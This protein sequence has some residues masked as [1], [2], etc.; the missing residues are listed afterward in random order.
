VVGRRELAAGATVA[1]AA[2]QSIAHRRIVAV[3]H[4]APSLAEAT[5]MARHAIV[6]PETSEIM[7]D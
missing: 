6:I 2:G 1:T 3:F 4:C 7:R 5:I